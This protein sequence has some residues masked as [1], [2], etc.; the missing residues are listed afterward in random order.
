MVTEKG[1]ELRAQTCLLLS[2]TSEVRKATIVGGSAGKSVFR[3]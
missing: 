2:S 3:V 1:L